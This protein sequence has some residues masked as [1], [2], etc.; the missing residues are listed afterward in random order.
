MSAIAVGRSLCKPEF[1][2][3]MAKS[4]V[5]AQTEA[6]L[7]PLIP[8][9]SK[10]ESSMTLLSETQEECDTFTFLKH[11]GTSADHSEGRLPMIAHC[12]EIITGNKWGR[13]H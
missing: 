1:R 8:S 12:P 5:K 13:K 10:V 2:S 4:S 9:S 6:A 11:I 7:S 3:G